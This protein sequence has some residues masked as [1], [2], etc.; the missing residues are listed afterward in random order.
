MPA[1]WEMSTI[2]TP[3]ARGRR[4]HRT[5]AERRA[6]SE[7]KLLRA[8]AQLIA[9]RGTSMVSF[10]DIAKLAGCSHGLPSYLFGTKAGLLQALLNDFTRRFREQA[11]DPAIRGASGLEA[12]L[13][14]VRVFL[15]SLDRPWPET[16]AIYV[17]QGEALGSSAELQA[18][19][20]DY[21][22]SLRS[23]FEA[24]IAE[25]ISDGDI[26]QT[27]RPDAQAVILLGILRGVG[28]QYVTDPFA[29]DLGTLTVEVLDDVTNSLAVDP[30][31]WRKS[32]T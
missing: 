32:P 3:S 10:G 15:E 19:L 11:L 5:Q 9:E 2:G 16:R 20:A 27:V 22:T 4:T 1:G 17:L 28:H 26:R 31:A 23:L 14:T 24:W 18:A 7:R 25:G 21:N 29:L 12:L 8:T 30:E 6:T 13:I